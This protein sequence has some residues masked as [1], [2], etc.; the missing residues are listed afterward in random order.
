MNKSFLYPMLNQHSP[1]SIKA[2]LSIIKIYIN[3]TLT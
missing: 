1:L 3:S 2:K